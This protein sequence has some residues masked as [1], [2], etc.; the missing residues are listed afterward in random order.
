ML[1]IV[2]PDLSVAQNTLFSKDVKSWY[3]GWANDPDSLG[4]YFDST[5]TQEQKDSL[6]AAMQRWNAAGCV[7]KFKQVSS[8]DDAH[9]TITRAPEPLGCAGE[10]VT[11]R[12]NHD[13][14]VVSAEIT[15][16]PDHNSP[17]N[18]VSLTE[19]VTH[20][21]G[22][23]LG[24]KDTDENA[25]PGDVMKGM[26]T[27][28]SDGHLSKHDS[29]EMRQAAEN[30]TYF[31]EDKPDYRY[32]IFPDKA[33]MPGEYSILTFLLP[34]FY[35][36]GSIVM[37]EPMH[38]DMLFV[39]MAML[40]DNFL[41]VGL[42]T[43]PEHYSGMIYLNVQTLTPDNEEYQCIGVHYVNQFP[44]PQIAFDCPFSIMEYEGRYLIDWE[45]FHTYPF[46][47][48]LRATLFVDEIIAYDVK[49]NGNFFIDLAPGEH[50]LELFV[51]DYQVN[52]AYHSMSYI[53]IQ[54]IQINEVSDY[55]PYPGEN[56][57]VYGEHFGEFTPECAVEIN[58]IVFHD[59]ITYWSDNEVFFSFPYFPPGEALFRLM[60]NPVEWSNPVELFI[61]QPETAY[62]ILP[63]EG[64]I[65]S[66]NIV[67]LYAA[68]EIYQEL[69]QSASF[70]FRP[71]DAPDWEFIGTDWDGANKH[72]STT[73]PLG[74]GDG[75]SVYWDTQAI[76]EM[77]VELKVEMTD[78]FGNVLSGLRSVV[79][80][81]EPLVPFINVDASKLFG[82]KAIDDDELVFE[83]E[84]TDA[85]LANIEFWWTPP[86]PGPGGWNYER[87]LEPVGQYSITFVDK[88]NRDIRDAACG[89]C[90]MTSCLKWLSEKYPESQ[91][92]KKTKEELAKELAKDA[93]T[94]T[95]G[96]RDDNLEAAV[97]KML[98][99]DPVTKDK[100][101]V[102]RHQNNRRSKSGQEHNVCDDI[103]RGLRD[104]ADV[105]MLILQLDENGDTLGHY[106][107]AS[108]HH[109]AISYHTTDTYCAAIQTSY[110]DFMDPS[111]GETEYKIINWYDN[112]PQIQDYDLDTTASGNA[113]VQSVITIKPKKEEKAVPKDLLIA[114]F[115]VP[116]PGSYQLAIPSTAFVTG[117]NIVEIFGVDSYGNRAGTF[118][119]CVVGDY[120]PIANF[121]AD[122]QSVAA[123]VPVQ[124]TDISNPKDS[125]S[126][127]QWAFGDGKTSDEQHPQ[128][129]FAA[130]GQY[131]VQLVVSDG[132]LF[133]TIVRENYIS[134]GA[135]PSQTVDLF[136]GWSGISSFIDPDNS[137]LETIF[138]PV[139]DEL[140]ILYN[141]S[142]FYW[143]SLN[144]NSLTNWDAY[145]GY[146]A[147]AADDITVTL[148]GL[149]V[150]SNAINLSQGW[151]LI[152]VFN[153]M[154]ATAVLNQLPGFVVA[155]G[156]ANAE[157]LWPVYNINTMPVMK[158]GSAYYVYTTQAGSISFAKGSGEDIWEAAEIITSTP[159]NEIAPSPNTHLI[160]F[161][162]ESLKKLREGD[163]LAA[164]TPTG[165]CA[166]A[167]IISDIENPVVLILNGDD[168]TVSEKSGYAPGDPISLSVYR[169]STDKLIDLEV[170]WDK[171]TNASGL[172]ET[173]GL[174]AVIDLTLV[175]TGIIQ[176]AQ[177]ALSIYPNPTT[178]KFTISGINETVEVR[179]YSAHG[180]EVFIESINLP[181]DVDLTS[182]PKGVYFISI[183]TDDLR[184]FK[185]I[186]K[187]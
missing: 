75:W 38:N 170:T 116:G 98:D 164:F 145:S 84:I 83:I 142:G 184:L 124:F 80:D 183:K 74:T 27:N 20:E 165:N 162:N 35:P 118:V 95:T 63:N 22:H 86:I 77:E 158:L 51:D 57:R 133:D 111:T 108:S 55:E 12:R 33:I 29:L 147:K 177:S 18:P 67:H 66:E 68:A 179:I 64:A 8:P 135:P 40:Y 181:V 154:A 89:P 182:H 59:V 167:A 92:A 61:I 105:V 26:G 180:R 175:S 99:S 163:M 161:T 54:E 94:D 151:N 186:L 144:I 185:R 139:V 132:V 13:D 110:V 114:Q 104:S 90:A 73:G 65:V 137:E 169:E 107:T 1:L 69:I 103:A 85:D 48:P 37:V 58:G 187:N 119:T 25:N 136:Q 130:E 42:F 174:S 30:I 71:V 7:P 121:T 23:A 153:Q 97:K 115:A 157:I 150:S 149:D 171:T 160:A 9:I 19:V 138:A 141:F 46:A 17:P 96:T 49:P 126:S 156:V 16:S 52:N 146:V 60:K 81:K 102:Q 24:L 143:P 128:H 45:A 15:I 159:W 122:K 62:F 34:N 32:A 88:N 112:P 39:E 117:V 100:F 113:W 2:S 5:W 176:T 21:L 79:I 93:E 91:I 173:H 87:E 10:C 123:G 168:P 129:T 44:A 148:T 101:E 70:Y 172:F 4:V 72:Y 125:I 31:G 120:Q 140:I 82:G 14:K 11:S 178:G 166:G 127:W 56:L 50:V 78:I 134:V 41:E 6:D 28:G 47:N 43:L 36:P 76:D 109:S 3:V 106:V 53:V 155:K 131:T 152:P